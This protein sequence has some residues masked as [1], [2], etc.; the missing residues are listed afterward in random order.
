MLGIIYVNGDEGKVQASIIALAVPE[1]CLSD[2]VEAWERILD[3]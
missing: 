1:N 2:W 3:K